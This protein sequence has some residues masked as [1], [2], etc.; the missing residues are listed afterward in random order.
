MTTRTPFVYG[1]RQSYPHLHTVIML[2]GKGSTGNS[3]AAD[4][5]EMEVTRVCRGST[6]E[7]QEIDHVFPY[8]RWVFP[9]APFPDTKNIDGDWNLRMWFDMECLSKPHVGSEKQKLGLQK[10]IDEVLALIESEAKLVPRQNI[11]LCGFDQGMAVALATF[12]VGGIADFPGVIG[13]S[14]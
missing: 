4:F 10:S 13:L 8:I 6:Q 7:P 11:Y 14:G 2:H 1:P 3:F 9:W 12:I 5:F